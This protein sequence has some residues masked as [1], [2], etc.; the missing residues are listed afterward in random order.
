MKGIFKGLL[1]ALSLTFSVSQAQATPIVA[2]QSYE[3]VNK[4]TSQLSTTELSYFTV[5][6]DNTISA[7]LNLA[8]GNVVEISSLVLETTAA[9][10]SMNAPL[11]ATAF[12]AYKDVGNIFP[13]TNPTAFNDFAIA[14]PGQIYTASNDWKIWSAIFNHT[15]GALVTGQ[16]DYHLGYGRNV[17]NEVPEP[18]TMT[19]LGMGLVGGAIRR[20]RNAA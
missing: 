5:N 2:G 15:T 19:L 8:N 9:G 10:F 4:Y 20:R 11:G 7:I 3:L 16:S 12:G 17:T 18:M 6:L 14:M 13:E 1:A